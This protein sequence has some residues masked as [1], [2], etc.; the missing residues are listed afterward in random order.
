MAPL[1]LTIMLRILECWV[2]VLS[3]V[4]TSASPAKVEVT[5]RLHPFEMF[6]TWSNPLYMPY[7]KC[8]FESATSVL[9]DIIIQTLSSIIRSPKWKCFLK[10][11]KIKTR[12]DFELCFIFPPNLKYCIINLLWDLSP[13]VPSFLKYYLFILC[14]YA[15][16]STSVSCQHGGRTVELIW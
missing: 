5:Q 14:L 7:W 6:V 9:N 10:N 13:F 15:S 11:L 8:H 16:N 1:A 2:M 4:C 3:G 12:R